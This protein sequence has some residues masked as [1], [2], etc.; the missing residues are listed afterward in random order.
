MGTS[1]KHRHEAAIRNLQ[2]MRWELEKQQKNV[3]FIQKE[4]DK[5]AAKIEEDK[6]KASHARSQLDKVAKSF[7]GLRD[8]LQDRARTT[9]HGDKDQGLLGLR[10]VNSHLISSDLEDSRG[11]SC[12]PGTTPSVRK[13]PQ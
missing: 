3:D 8:E 12:Q 9:I 6:R 7:G 13:L 2:T 1:I 10:K 5:L 4:R 11:Y